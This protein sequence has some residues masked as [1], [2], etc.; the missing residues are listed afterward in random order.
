MNQLNGLL[1]RARTLAGALVTYLTIAVG[2]VT[3]IVANVDVPI[4][5]E[6]GATAIAILVGAIAIVRRVTPVAAN[7]R[8]LA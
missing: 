7:D 6:Y 3:Y 1:D 4:V 2:V 5:G 8:G